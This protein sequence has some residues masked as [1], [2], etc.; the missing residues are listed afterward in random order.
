MSFRELSYPLDI[1][2]GALKEK[3]QMKTGSEPANMELSLIDGTVLKD[4][5]QTLA[6]LGISATNC[7]LSLKDVDASSLANHV[8]DEVPIAPVVGKADEGF[9]AFRQQAQAEVDAN[10]NNRVSTG[11][12]AATPE[13]KKDDQ[14]EL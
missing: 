5:T 1:T 14:D 9:K 6:E 10:Q 3:L 2:L 13:A 4:D 8:L 11:E 7:D 12:A